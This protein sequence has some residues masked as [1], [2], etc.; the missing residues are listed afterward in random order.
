[1]HGNL[2][3]VNVVGVVNVGVMIIK[4]MGSKWFY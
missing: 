1:M 3:K 2:K 4:L